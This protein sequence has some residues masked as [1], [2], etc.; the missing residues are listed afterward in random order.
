MDHANVGVSDCT[1][2]RLSAVRPVIPMCWPWALSYELCIWRACSC[3]A[4]LVSVFFRGSPLSVQMELEPTVSFLLG[5]TVGWQG[6]PCSLAL[7]A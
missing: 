5:R 3:S 4:V 1:L 6:G 7:G 2:S